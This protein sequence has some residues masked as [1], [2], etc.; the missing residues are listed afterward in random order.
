LRDGD[1]DSESL[2]A[3]GTMCAAR[4]RVGFNERIEGTRSSRQ[5][6][7]SQAPPF[8]RFAQT[9][10]PATEEKSFED[11]AQALAS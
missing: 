2:L 3:K 9:K 7:G 4:A 11:A 1:V 10:A 5:I 8:P 6:A